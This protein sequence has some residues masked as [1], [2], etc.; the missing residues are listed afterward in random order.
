MENTEISVVAKKLF[1]KHSMLLPWVPQQNI[2]FMRRFLCLWRFCLEGVKTLHAMARGSTLSSAVAPCLNKYLVE[3]FY[4][5]SSSA[6]QFPGVS[7]C[8]GSQTMN[9]SHI[10]KTYKSMFRTKGKSFK[11]YHFA[12]NKSGKIKQFW[13]N[14]FSVKSE[15][16]LPYKILVTNFNI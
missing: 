5:N 10:E 14:M 7:L 3:D 1:E 4:P 9:V 13:A 8:P 2:R 11:F 6:T 12:Y 16:K 15:V